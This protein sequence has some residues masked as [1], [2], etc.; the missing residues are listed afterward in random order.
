MWSAICRKIKSRNTHVGSQIQRN[1]R[2]DLA[3]KNN[4]GLGIGTLIL[5]EV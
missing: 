1:P 3:R 4:I 2:H 5:K